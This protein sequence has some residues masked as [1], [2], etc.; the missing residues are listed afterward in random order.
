MKPIAVRNQTRPLETPL[1][2]RSCESFWCKLRGLTFRRHLATNEGL[3]LVEPKASRL[4]AGI[5]MLWMFFDLSILWL[6]DEL[7]VVDKTR[8][9]PWVSFVF[10]RQPARY[11]I[12]CSVSRYEEFQIGD[13]LVFEEPA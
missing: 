7:K 4:N 8:A 12:E 5:H 11:V 9:R 10:P 2:L 13:Q 1:H 3:L 6:G